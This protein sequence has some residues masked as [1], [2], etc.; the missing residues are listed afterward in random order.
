MK[1]IIHFRHLS[2]PRPRGWGVVGVVAFLLSTGG[3]AKVTAITSGEQERQARQDRGELFAGQQPLTG[4]LTLHEAMARALKYN[5]DLRLKRMEE[6]LSGHQEDVALLEMLPKLTTAA[7]YS[8]RAPDTSSVSKSMATGMVSSDPSVSRDSTSR[9]ADLTLSWNLLDFGMSY[10]QTR[11]E[12][13]KHLIQSEYRRKA[14]HNLLKDVRFAY[15]KAAAAQWL[16]REIGTILQASE[17]AMELARKV[18]NEN[19]RSPVH[20]LQFQLGLL[21]IMRQMEKSRADLAIAREELATLIHLPPGTAFQ[22]V[23]DSG[24]MELAPDPGVPVEELER[25]ALAARPELRI[26]QY[27]ARIE[28]DETR[29]AIARLFPGLEFA[30]S[31][32]YDDNTYLVYQHWAQAGARLSWNL[33]RTL[34]RAPQMS[35]ADSRENVV[36]LRRLVLHMAVVS[37]TRI[38]F[39]EYR[40][41]RDALRRLVVESDTRRRLQGHTANRSGMGLESQLA[42]VHNVAAAALGRIQQYEAFARHQSALGR[43]YATL[44]MDHLSGEN[45]EREIALLTRSLR[46]NDT[47]WRQMLF[48][49][50][51]QKPLLD[52]RSMTPLPLAGLLPREGN[53]ESTP[54][55]SAEQ[56]SE[57]PAAPPSVVEPPPPAPLPPPVVEPSPESAST[58][59]HSKAEPPPLPTP[60][61]GKTLYV[62]QVASTPDL[63]GVN[64][65]VAALQAKG[66]TPYVNQVAG[67]DGRD[68]FQIWIGRFAQGQE[69]VAARDAYQ[70]R[71]RQ[72]AFIKTVAY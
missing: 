49:S 32:S 34:T 17:E 44:G 66:Y 13:N 71:E 5:L 69:A 70:K 41:S 36:Q 10:Y 48:A 67:A 3:C 72:R 26:E 28:A 14:A 55:P 45:P 63:S 16:E 46:E 8:D 7:G 23:D 43:L 57:P 56:R 1:M 31:A 21:E 40:A 2:V 18:E 52:D 58:P 38:A 61:K 53:Q 11:Q 42:Y 6:V 30:V 60:A 64:G 27:Q 59:A 33:V 37:Q 20:A 50:A 68:L 51:S 24:A 65:L 9:T 62:V 22:L 47:R 54:A 19:L 39:H 29:K 4:P 35:L 15:W 25:M 12:A